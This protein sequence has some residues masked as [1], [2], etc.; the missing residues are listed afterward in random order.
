MVLDVYYFLSPIVNGMSAF[1]IPRTSYKGGDIFWMNEEVRGG[2]CMTV[3]S[4]TAGL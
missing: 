3:N 2:L 1:S 4:F